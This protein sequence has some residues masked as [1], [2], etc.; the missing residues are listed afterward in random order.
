VQTESDAAFMLR[1][2]T[3]NPDDREGVTTIY[4]ATLTMS[5]FDTKNPLDFF[6]TSWVG[7]CGSSRTAQCAR[8][9][10]AGMDSEINPIVEAFS[11]QRK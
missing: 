7:Q 1:V 8:N 9:V 3:L 4:S 11:R 6:L 2:V 5:N 10:I